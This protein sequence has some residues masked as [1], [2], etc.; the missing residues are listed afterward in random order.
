MEEK[1]GEEGEKGIRE[2]EGDG[3]EERDGEDERTGK[4]LAKGG[5]GIRYDERKREEERMRGKGKE[6]KR[7]DRVG[8]EGEEEE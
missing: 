5:E 1:G 6:K 2:G 7:K 8:K 3:G 4:G